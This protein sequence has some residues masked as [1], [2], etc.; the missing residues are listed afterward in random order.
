M[1]NSFAPIWAQSKRREEQTL[2]LKVTA[3]NGVEVIDS[4]EVAE[5]TGKL[6]AHLMRDIKGYVEIIENSNESK[7]GSVDFF[8]PSTYTDSKGETRPRYLLTRKGCDMVANKMTGEKGVLFTAA[9]VTAFEEMQKRLKMSPSPAEQLLAQAQL[10]VDQERRIA[11]LE[12]GQTQMRD[13]M[14]TAF[15]ALASPTVSRDHWQVETRSR[16]RQMC[17]EFDLNFQKE[18]GSLYK[19]LEE[20]AG[21][22][23]EVRVKHQ[24]ERMKVGGAK[25]ADRQAVNK[26]TVIAQDQRLREIFAGIVQRRYAQLVAAKMPKN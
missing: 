7:F 6:H 21:C 10:M 5:M 11:A 18:T 2:T 9:Y 13:T 24:R 4:R 26:L 16:I 1:L 19:S 23:L 17:M 3:S 22:N 25:Y 12:T 15:S 8:I 20:S 14:S